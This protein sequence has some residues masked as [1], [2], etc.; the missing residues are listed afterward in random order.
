[1][2]QSIKRETSPKTSENP[3]T[4]LQNI[5]RRNKLDAKNSKNKRKKALLFSSIDSNLL[6]KYIILLQIK[7]SKSEIRQKTQQKVRLWISQSEHKTENQKKKNRPLET[8]KRYVFPSFSYSPLLLS[9]SFFNQVIPQSPFHSSHAKVRV[10]IRKKNKQ[11]T[12]PKKELLFLSLQ[13]RFN[14]PN[15]MRDSFRAPKLICLGFELFTRLW[16]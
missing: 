13:S 7:N 4:I 16:I 8:T 10:F 1:M 5:Q 15:T 12:Q 2:E 11:K 14:I 9:C 3:D 6:A